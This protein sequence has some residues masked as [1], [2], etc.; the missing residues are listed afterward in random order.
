[1]MTNS[2]KQMYVMQYLF[3]TCMSLAIVTFGPVGIAPF[4]DL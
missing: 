4:S 3:N 2:F 1:M